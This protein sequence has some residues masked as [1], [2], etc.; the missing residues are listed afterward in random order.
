MLG[1]LSLGE[2]GILSY[3]KATVK[4]KNIIPNIRPVKSQVFLHQTTLPVFPLASRS[5]WGPFREETL[6]A[7]SLSLCCKDA[8]PP[9][10]LAERDQEQGRR[11]RLPALPLGGRHSNAHLSSAG[12]T[13]SPLLSRIGGCTPLNPRRAFGLVPLSLSH[14]LLPGLGMIDHNQRPIAL[15]AH[16]PAFS[17]APP[18]S[19]RHSSQPDS[20]FLFKLAR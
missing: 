4:Q 11:P 8:F 2:E 19:Q 20:P 16:H 14:S 3:I 13:F 18:S 12:W 5:I 7:S 1:K 15:T 10:T 17:I 9:D 6:T